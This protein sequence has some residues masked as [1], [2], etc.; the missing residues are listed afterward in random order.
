MKGGHTW[1]YSRVV[2]PVPKAKKHPYS[3]LGRSWSYRI[4]RDFYV[5]ESCGWTLEPIHLRT[6]RARDACRCIYG[7]LQ[8]KINRVYL[9]KM[10]GGCRQSLTESRKQHTIGTMVSR[11][12][13]IRHCRAQ[14]IV[15]NVAW[16][17]PHILMTMPD[18][19]SRQTFPVRL[20][21]RLP[22]ITTVRVRP[23]PTT[24]RRQGGGR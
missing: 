5:D 4:Q 6:K 11:C 8:I 19:A 21:R 12:L 13:P 18:F 1:A 23:S 16:D 2:C 3:T 10:P 14:R 22:E 17:I 15:Q 7:S 24:F 9:Y 20:P